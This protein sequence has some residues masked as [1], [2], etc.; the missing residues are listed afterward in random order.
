MRLRTKATRQRNLSNWQIRFQQELLRA[1]DT[2]TTQI[3]IRREAYGQ[4]KLCGEVH[5]REANTGC[6][7]AQRERLCEM[8]LHIVDSAA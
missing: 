3:C 4:P 7:A 2:T 5:T 1:F 6:D 8:S